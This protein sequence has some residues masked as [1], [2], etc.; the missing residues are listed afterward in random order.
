MRIVAEA[1]EGYA[2]EWDKELALVELAARAGA[3]AI[4][5]QL[6]HPDELLTP[7]HPLYD[8]VDNL[9][10]PADR[11]R[12]VAE[13]AG[14]MEVELLFDV[15]GRHGLELAASLGVAAV[16]VHGSDMLNQVLLG[17]VGDS[18]VPE[19]LLSAG[20]T[21]FEE[22]GEAIALLPGKAIT[23]VVGFQAYPTPIPENRLR[24]LQAAREAFP[25]AALGFADHTGK[26]EAAAVW[27]PALAIA[28]GAT[29]V[30]KHIT[31][32]HVLGDPDHQSA[33]APDRFAEFVENMRLGLV[34]LGE[35]VDAMGEPERAYRLKMKKHVIAARDLPAGTSLG[36]A[37]LVLKRAPD[38]PADV[39]FRLDEAIGAVLGSD[40]KADEPLK[41]GDLR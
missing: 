41:R 19:V 40:V 37:E 20:G 11:W 30:E 7:A 29:Y 13:R 4:K 38:P 34:A 27:L 23:V 36:E 39:L 2:A 22:V 35:P 8:L 28:L 6:L 26:D 33:L 14:E 15:F 17:E 1:A 25:E 18:S 32:A 9:Q 21:T 12:A 5:F 10:L 16:K 3:T 31:V 24:R